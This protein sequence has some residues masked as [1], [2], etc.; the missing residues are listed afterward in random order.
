VEYVL[1]GG[2]DKSLNKHVDFRALEIGYGSVSAVS[3]SDHNGGTSIPA[4]RVL[5]FS[6]GF[7]FRFP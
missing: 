2:L 5:N 1:S 3:S 6:T 4:A 7:V